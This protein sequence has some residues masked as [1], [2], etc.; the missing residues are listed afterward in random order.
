ML[1]YHI[2]IKSSRP[3]SSACLLME[4]WDQDR[5]V[6]LPLHG[7]LQRRQPP[8]ARSASSKPASESPS[9]QPEPGN[10]SS[11]TMTS[12]HS[13][14]FNS[15]RGQIDGERLICNESLEL[16]TKVIQ[17][18]RVGQLNLVQVLRVWSAA[19]AR[20]TWT[21]HVGR[22]VPGLRPKNVLV[23]EEDHVMLS[24][25]IATSDHHE[26]PIKSCRFTSLS[27]LDSPYHRQY[28]FFLMYTIHSEQYFFSHVPQH[29]PFAWQNV[30]PL[31]LLYDYS[32]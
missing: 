28:F 2:K 16:G 1:Y 32:F 19:C 30:S 21:T 18:T 6:L 9:T 26:S 5:Q 10:N 3:A 8:L 23:S 29:T 20:N 12:S 14:H 13:H 4:Y 15:E 22:G 17:M 25:P 7:V 27:H 11:I 24:D 31:K